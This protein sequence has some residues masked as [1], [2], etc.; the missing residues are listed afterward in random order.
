MVTIRIEG[1]GCCLNTE[2]FIIAE[3]L[4]K[5]DGRQVTIID[6]NG[7]RHEI[8]SLRHS[9]FDTTIVIEDYPSGD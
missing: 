7:L 9:L 4:N 5:H 2:A 8:K 6:S 3:A 1:P